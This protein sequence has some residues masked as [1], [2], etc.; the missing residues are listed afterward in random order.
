MRIVAALTASIIFLFGAGAQ[1]LAPKGTEKTPVAVSNTNYRSKLPSLPMPTKAQVELNRQLSNPKVPPVEYWEAVAIC[2]SSLDGKTARW[3]DG[4]R[5]SGGLG[6]WIGTW[7]RWGGREF[8]PSPSLATK[9][10]QIVVANRI[11]VLGYHFF[12]YSKQPVGF[13]GWGCIEKRKSLNPK[14]WINKKKG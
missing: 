7:V 13:Y 4:G 10:E 12:S 5:W 11:A 9:T 2:E 3:D 6:I 1:A 14:L 8:A